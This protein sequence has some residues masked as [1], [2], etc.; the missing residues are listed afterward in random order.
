TLGWKLGE[1]ISLLIGD[2]PRWIVNFFRLDITKVKPTKKFLKDKVLDS[3]IL[4]FHKVKDL[5][6]IRSSITHYK[7]KTKVI[8]EEDVLHCYLIV[9]FVID[10]LLK[11]QKNG[12]TK[13]VYDKADSVEKKESSLYY[14]V[15]KK[16]FTP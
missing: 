4:L 10:K 13:L 1:R 5:Y 15:D 8:P 16:K 7:K 14:W 9:V 11:L 12:I 2:D 6:D 3:R